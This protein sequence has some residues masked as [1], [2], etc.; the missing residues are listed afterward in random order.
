M[1]KALKDKLK[2]ALKKFTKD[3]EKASDVV[4]APAEE[5]KEEIKKDIEE[6][7]ETISNISEEKAVEEKKEIKEEKKGFFGKIKSVFV[8]EEESYRIDYETSNC[9]DGLDP[10]VR[11]N[12]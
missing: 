2:G 12:L 11:H 4:E 10:G 1:F 9:T 7:E 5:K 3:V 8:K 6:K